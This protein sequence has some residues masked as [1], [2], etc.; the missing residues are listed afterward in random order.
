MSAPRVGILMGSLSDLD[1]MMEAVRVL[2]GYGI[3]TEVKVLS[4]HRA[5]DAVA[6]YARSARE[7]GLR[8]LVAGAGGAA[9]LAGALAAHSTLP[10]LG[11][12]LVASALA[13]LDAL[14]ATVQMP[15][16]VPVATLGVGKSGAVNAG[17][18]AAR[19]LALGDDDVAGGV[20]DH[21][22]AQLDKVE[23]MGVELRE[24]L[25]AE[26]LG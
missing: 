6:E 15:G 11:V 3:G 16:G 23:R 20:A 14:L 1:I 7:R 26:G 4:A 24:R 12:P 2:D 25:E 19:I 9:H 8:I 10:I 17:H 5:P 18:L 22:A 21:R 13:G